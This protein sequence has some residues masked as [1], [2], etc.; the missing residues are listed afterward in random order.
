[1]L[2]ALG[3][4]AHTRPR[5]TRIAQA[6][7]LFSLVFFTAFYFTFSFR[8]HVIFIIRKGNRHF[9]SQITNVP[10]KNKYGFKGLNFFNINSQVYIG[11]VYTFQWIIY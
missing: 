3:S 2:I 4:S 5:P 10:S 7:L 9:C 6:C 11:Q 1:M 8:F